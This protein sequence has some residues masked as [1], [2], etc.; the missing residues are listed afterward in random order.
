MQKRTARFSLSFRVIEKY[1]FA[2]LVVAAATA[3]MFFIGRDVLGEGVIALLYLAP[4]SWVTARWG[5]GPG[6]LAAVASALAFDFLF[7]PPFFT[8]NIGSLEGWLLLGI[9]LGVA[10]VVVGRIQHGLSQAQA[11]KREATLMYEL[12]VV[13]AG[14]HTREDVTRTLARQL[15][16]FYQAELIQVS[17]EGKDGPAVVDIPQG[18]SVAGKPD[19]VL[20]IMAAK[21]MVGE[22]RMWRNG[23]SLTPADDQLL[24]NLTH[25]SALALERADF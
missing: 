25:L 16:Q 22:V 9:F 19:L 7:I 18:A 2:L 21:G 10:I 14:A 11:S 5:Q 4:I 15:Q 13:L 1:L 17:V 24:K 20:P 8:F 23:L 6:I 3:V 12:S